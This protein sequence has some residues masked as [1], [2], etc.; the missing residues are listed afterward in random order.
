MASRSN[1]DQ[2]EIALGT[3]ML[4]Q[5]RQTI[6]GRKKSIDDAVDEAEG[7]PEPKKKKKPYDDE[8]SE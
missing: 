3:G 7:A 8:E 4:E 5:A 6:S 1:K 2:R